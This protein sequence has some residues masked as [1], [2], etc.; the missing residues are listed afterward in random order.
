VLD[1]FTHDLGDP[2]ESR[3]A[4]A[5][6]FRASGTCPTPSSRAESVSAAEDVYL[7]RN[8]FLENRILGMPR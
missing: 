6:Q 7:V 4:G 1:D 5:L 3:L 8:P 2:L